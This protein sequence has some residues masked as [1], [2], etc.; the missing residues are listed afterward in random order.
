LARV[1]ARFSGFRF[2]FAFAFATVGSLRVGVTSQQT[3]VRAKKYFA[4][5]TK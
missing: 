5:T 1:L 2:Y 4:T 3:G